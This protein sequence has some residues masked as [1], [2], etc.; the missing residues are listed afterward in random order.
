MECF[1]RWAVGGQLAVDN[2]ANNAADFL[3]RLYA[4]VPG[5]WYRESIRRI[6][7]E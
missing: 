2:R 1:D 5:L 4:N 7:E 6:G 3:S